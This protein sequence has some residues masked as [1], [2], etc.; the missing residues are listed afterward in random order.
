M[1]TA[2][3]QSRPTPPG[4]EDLQALY[5]QVLAGFVD[6]SP[7]AERSPTTIL[8][9]SQQ[10]ER[11]L[12]AL[13]SAYGGE[14]NVDLGRSFSTTAQPPSRTPSASV[15]QKPSP[16]PSPSPRLPTNPRDVGRPLPSLQSG[17]SGRGMRPL[18]RPPGSS[19]SISS[20][21]PPMPEPR[22]YYS[23]ESSA[24]GGKSAASEPSV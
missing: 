5:N 12:E 3:A 22:P 20:I 14:A 21:G 9:S 19:A 15:A 8:S 1:S 24:G 7:T 13:Y 4:E 2:A 17:H 11:D 10:G 18:P 16:S 23:P 6:E